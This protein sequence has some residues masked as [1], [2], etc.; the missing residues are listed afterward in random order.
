MKLSDETRAVEMIRSGT[1]TQHQASVRE[2]HESSAMAKAFLKAGFVDLQAKVFSNVDDYSPHRMESL[3]AEVER[4]T[5][6][7]H[8]Y[9]KAENQI[10]VLR[11]RINPPV[12]VVATGPSLSP[13]DLSAINEADLNDDARDLVLKR[14][15]AGT[16]QDDASS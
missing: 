11:S 5:D 15:E 12:G 10:L 4:F 8:A 16:N 7:I 1:E 9:K 14:F 13:A 6:A 3:L 2:A